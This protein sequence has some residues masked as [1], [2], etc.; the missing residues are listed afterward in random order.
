[1]KMQLLERK[2]AASHSQNSALLLLRQICGA[3][4]DVQAGAKR[5]RLA[6]TRTSGCRTRRRFASESSPAEWFAR[7]ECGCISLG[8]IFRNKFPEFL[9]PLE[10]PPGTFLASA[11]ETALPCGG[12]GGWAP[13]WSFS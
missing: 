7:S 5:I 1:M 10:P 13:R 11:D 8:E 9:P 4:C 12:L 3:D 2:N 6:G